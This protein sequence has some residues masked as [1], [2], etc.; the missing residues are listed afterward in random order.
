MC[1]CLCVCFLC[2]LLQAAP[3]MSAC[4]SNTFLECIWASD[5][6]VSPLYSR[7]KIAPPLCMGLQAEG[8]F[9]KSL[10][11]HRVS[12][13]LIASVAGARRPARLRYLLH[14]ASDH[15]R[16]RARQILRSGSQ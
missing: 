8:V 5:A 9:C 7:G 16:I 14:S 1:V 6:S 3:R 2:C 13:Y 10:G 15:Q 12:I 4:M 11:S